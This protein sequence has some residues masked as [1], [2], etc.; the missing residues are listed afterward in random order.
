MARLLNARSALNGCRAS[1]H[2]IRFLHFIFKAMEGTD[3]S[4]WSFNNFDKLLEDLMN[5]KI[6]L[7]YYDSSV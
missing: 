6:H 7:K 1:G 3:S 4:L 2:K 5:K